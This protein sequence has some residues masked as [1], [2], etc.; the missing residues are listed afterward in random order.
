MR[1]AA[2]EARRV[3]SKWRRKRLSIPAD[4][5]RSPTASCTQSDPS[6]KVSYAELIGG[7][8]FNVPL[9]WNK[10][11]ATRS[12]RRKAK[13]KDPKDYKI[14]GKPLPREDIAPIVYAQTDFCTDVKRPGMLHAA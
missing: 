9:E 14:V 2:A 3:L 10:E 12:M 6:K 7:R 13:P 1:V 11:L 8:Y 5:S 4:S